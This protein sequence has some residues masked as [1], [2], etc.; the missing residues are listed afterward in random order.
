M[1]VNLSQTESH[2][3]RALLERAD[4]PSGRR[5]VTNNVTMQSDPMPD[6]IKR[7]GRLKHR[8]PPKRRLL[9]TT[10]SSPPVS[11]QAKMALLVEVG[12]RQKLLRG[13]QYIDG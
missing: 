12:F 2:A 4:D 6:R 8:A 10:Q 7:V 11:Q 13:P 3:R 9:D 5:T 1:G